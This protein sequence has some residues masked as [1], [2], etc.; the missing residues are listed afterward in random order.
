M[1]AGMTES[2]LVGG[3]RDDADTLLQLGAQF[4]SS[5]RLAPAADCYRR[6][7]AADPGHLLAWSNLIQVLINDRQT[8]SIDAE[9]AR[10][11]AGGINPVV[12]ALTDALALPIIYEDRDDV[13]RWRQRALA[14]LATLAA[15]GGQLPLAALHAVPAHF[16]LAYH[17]VD[18]RSVMLDLA[19]TCRQVCPELAFT[20]PHVDR[21]R[22]PGERIHLG[23]YS[24]NLRSHTVGKLNFG[25][26]K[27]LDRARFKLTLFVPPHPGDAF[28]EQ[29]RSAAEQTIEVPPDL[30]GIRAAIAGEKLDALLFP[31]IGMD[32]LTTFVAH[33]RLAPLQMTSWGHPVTTGIPTIDEFLSSELLE[34]ADADRHYSERLVRFAHLPT[35]YQRY[36]LP[37]LKSAQELGLPSD[38]HL[39]F[40]PQSLFKLHPDF[41]SMLGGILASDGRAEILLLSG[42]VDAWN[43]AILARLQRRLGAL[44]ARVRFLPRMGLTQFLS[45]L[46]AVDVV[47]DTPHF[48]G[49]NTHYDALMVGAAVVTWPGAHMRGRVGAGALRQIG[50]SDLIADDPDDYVARALR[51]AKDRDF[52]QTVREAILKGGDRLYHDLGWLRDFENH[53]AQALERQATNRNLA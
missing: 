32:R 45:V 37:P 24:A 21:W 33:A 35:C 4:S 9:M 15:A 48:G 36:L 29:L 19:G 50:V 10:A 47:L 14:R 20:A 46:R 41:D 11:L 53:V 12:V 7:L 31:D 2:S 27:Y 30:I 1:S 18:D 42:P 22:G 8:A 38:R 13:E 23:I 25:L 26:V 51:S 34:P 44:A 43:A 28:A 16:G 40:C 3:V 49:G 6:L 5:G 39:Y 52:R 17:G